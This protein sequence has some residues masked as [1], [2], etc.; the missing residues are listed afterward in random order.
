MAVA[1]SALIRMRE[2]RFYLITAL[3]FPLVVLIG[4]GRTYYLKT[5]T[6]AP[7]LSSY[8]VQIHGAIM[9]MWVALYI[10]QVYLVRS[11]QIRVHQTLG[12]AGIGLAV[13]VVISGFFTA[14]AAAKNGSASFPPDVPRMSF[15]AVPL[16]DLL[17]F[18]ALFTAAVYYRKRAAN[19]KRLMLVIAIGL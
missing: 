2:K 8:L 1:E 18:S 13:L 19:H 16:F 5:F 11:K 12:F 3:L 4:F 15:L 10:A 6:G 14:I 7:P 17:T 9:T